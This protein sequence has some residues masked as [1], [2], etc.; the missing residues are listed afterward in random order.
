MVDD[1]S[2]NMSVGIVSLGVAAVSFIIN[3]IFVCI[4]IKSLKKTFHNLLVILLCANDGNISF[5]IVIFTLMKIIMNHNKSQCVVHICALSYGFSTSYIINF[6]ICFTRFFTIRSLNYGVLCKFERYKCRIVFGAHLVTLGLSLVSTMPFITN[7]IIQSCDP[8]KLL[9]EHYP[10]YIALL[11][12]PVSFLIILIIAMYILSSH[13][14]WI[15]FFKHSSKVGTMNLSRQKEFR[16]TANYLGAGHASD[17]IV[18]SIEGQTQKNGQKGLGKDDKSNDYPIQGTARKISISVN[19]VCDP[20]NSNAEVASVQNKEMVDLSSISRHDQSISMAK[21]ARNSWEVRAFE[22]NL[23]IAGTTVFL[24]SPFVVTFLYDLF[25][26]EPVSSNL[27]HALF[28][29]SG[30]NYILDPFI[31]AYRVPEIRREITKRVCKTSGSE[32]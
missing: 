20:L 17:H 25:V 28:T 9:D 10:L 5:F 19:Q 16:V 26:S 31:Y 29:L 30:V 18:K 15:R 3:G 14:I 12:V 27:R 2:I 11:W 7:K 23:L 6:L 21:I 24:T 8:P 1:R 22:T 4:A 32:E 13:M